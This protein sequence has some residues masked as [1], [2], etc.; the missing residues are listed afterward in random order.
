VEPKRYKQL[1]KAHD[2][3]M[4]NGVINMKLTGFAK[5]GETFESRF[6]KLREKKNRARMIFGPSDTLKL[7]G[8][9]IG[10]TLIHAGK[11]VGFTNMIHGMNTGDLENYIE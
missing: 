6:D 4:R 3:L 8:G 5:T 7:V 2:N 11:K 10:W 9:H 1:V